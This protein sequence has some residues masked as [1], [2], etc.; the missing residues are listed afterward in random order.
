M[1]PDRS[2]AAFDRNFDCHCVGESKSERGSKMGIPEN[3]VLVEHCLE[4]ARAWHVTRRDL[5]DRLGMA[6]VTSKRR[7]NRRH[8][9]G[10]YFPHIFQ[11]HCRDFGAEHYIPFTE[12]TQ[13]LRRIAALYKR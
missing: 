10:T 2:I 7:L 4:L 8:Y 9:N 5:E 6:T 12:N 1:P 3:N 13:L 11:G